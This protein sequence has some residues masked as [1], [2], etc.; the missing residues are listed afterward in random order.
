MVMFGFGFDKQRKNRYDSTVTRSVR[1]IKTAGSFFAPLT[2]GRTKDRGASARISARARS[3]A[4][5]LQ[6]RGQVDFDMR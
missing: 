4:G 3:N 5:D 1:F 6:G 2:P